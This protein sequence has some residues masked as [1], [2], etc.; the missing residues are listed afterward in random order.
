MLL[1]SRRDFLALVKASG[2]KDCGAS[3]VVV[4]K[5]LAHAGSHKGERQSRAD[6]RAR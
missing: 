1:Y 6:P 5:M 4:V 3:R 2:A